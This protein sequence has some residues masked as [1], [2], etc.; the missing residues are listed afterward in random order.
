MNGAAAPTEARAPSPTPAPVPVEAAPTAAPTP[1]APAVA[2]VAVAAAAPATT[3]RRSCST[4]RVKAFVIQHHLPLGL[5]VAVLIGF[6]APW[7][8]IVVG[9]APINTIS[10]CGIFFISGLQLRTDEVKKALGA[11]RASARRAEYRAGRKCTGPHFARVA[12]R[13]RRAIADATV[14]SPHSPT[15]G[16]YV[17]YIFGFI[18]I[19]G[20]SP[21]LSL[22]VARMPMQ[23][24]EFP[25]GLALFI[26]M[27]T[28]VSSGA[29]VRRRIGDTRRPAAACAPRAAPV[30]PTRDG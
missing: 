10:I 27:P 13:T 14:G 5:I 11:S 25:H 30:Q 17:A 16:S 6:V 4:A 1:P 26:A 20:L 7:P 9:Q 22:A 2:A 3:G 21:L 28:T 24:P 18:S 29:C 15:T 8:G 23:P 12:S 19:L